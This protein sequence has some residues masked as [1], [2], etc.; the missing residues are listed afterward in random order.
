VDNFQIFAV[1]FLL[2]P[3]YSVS[4]EHCKRLVKKEKLLNAFDHFCECWSGKRRNTSGFV[5]FW[6]SEDIFKNTISL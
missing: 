5:N 4:L 3:R 1:A 2:Q 6:K